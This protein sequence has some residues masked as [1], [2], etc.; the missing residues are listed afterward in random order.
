[1]RKSHPKPVVMPAFKTM[2]KPVIGEAFEKLS[3][4]LLRMK[5][6]REHA[7]QFIDMLQRN[8]KLSEVKSITPMDGLTLITLASMLTPED[9]NNALRLAQSAGGKARGKIKADDAK[10]DYA[11]YCKA[12]DQ[13]LLAGTPD[14]AIA[15]ILARRFEVTPQT[16]RTARKSQGWKK[17]KTS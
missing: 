3:K 13:L 4:P 5:E 12:A 17:T 7:Q 1:M 8:A 6:R 11:K 14:Q 16:I 9:R 2:F 10:D 15:S